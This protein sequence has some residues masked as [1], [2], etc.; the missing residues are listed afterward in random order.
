MEHVLS[1]NASYDAQ[2]NERTDIKSIHF[3]IHFQ[4]VLIIIFTLILKVS[5]T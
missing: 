1:K 3:T 5:Y 4:E 2:Q